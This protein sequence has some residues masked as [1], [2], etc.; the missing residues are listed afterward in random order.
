MLLG[1]AENAQSI[2]EAQSCMNGHHL[3]NVL[4]RPLREICNQRRFKGEAI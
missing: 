2:H 4:E 3:R 1:T